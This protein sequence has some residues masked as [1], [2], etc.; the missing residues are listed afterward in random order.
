MWQWWNYC[1]S[2]VPDGKA[3]LRINL[4]ETSI[5]LFQGDVTGTVFVPRKRQ[6]ADVVQNV[7]RSRRRRCL[8]HVALICDRPDIQVDLPQFIIGNEATFRVR[9]MDALRASSPRNVVLVRQKSAWNNEKLCAAIVRRLALALATHMNDLQPILIFDACRL[10]LTN[11][12]LSACVAARIWPIVVPAKLT[13]L[14]QPLDTHA[15]RPFKH[16][17]QQAYQQMRVNSA[18]DDPALPE[19]MECF[20]RAIRQVLQGRR[21]GDAFSQNGFGYH[22]TRLASRVKDE[23]GAAGP[24]DLPVARPTDEQLAVCF[25]R[26]GRVATV[27]FW[28]PFNGAAVPAVAKASSSGSAN[29]ASRLVEAPTA[30]SGVHC[31]GRTRS[32]TRALRCAASNPA[33]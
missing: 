17:L 14:L 9:D 6:H 4:D 20:Y 22:Q 11:I 12:V 15:F 7:P 1:E 31:I 16:E 21:W 10:H 24:F 18:G 23:L 32:E 5:C 3:V 2:K 27:I 28:R 26:R 13:W 29:R 8:T 19:F 30:I 33:P 25:P